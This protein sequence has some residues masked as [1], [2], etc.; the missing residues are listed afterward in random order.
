MNLMSLLARLSLDSSEYQQGLADSEDKA[1][2]AGS[3]IAKALGTM[4][5][6]VAAAS[7][8][9]AAAVG[10]LTYDAINSYGDYEQLLGGVET[11]FKDSADIVSAYAENAYKTAG[12]SSNEYMETVTSFSASLLQSLGGDT[13]KAAEYADL[14]ITDMSDNANKMGSSMESIQFAYQGFAKQ[15]YTMLDNLKL[16]YGGTKTEMERLIKDAEQLDDTFVATRDANG[17]LA[18][19]YSDIVDAIHIVQTEMGITGTTAKEASE[20]IQG[21]VNSM[22]ASWKNL[23]TGLGNTDADLSGLV[24]NF[25]DSLETAFSNIVPVAEQALT[26]MGEALPQLVGNLLPKFTQ[27]INNLLP[28]LIETV[29]NLVTSIGNA[30]P[31]I[32]SGL[33][34]VLPNLLQSIFSN[35]GEIAGN[36]LPSLAESLGSVLVNLPAMLVSTVDGLITGLSNMVTGIVDAVKKQ[37]EDSIPADLADGYVGKIQSNFEKSFSEGMTNLKLSVANLIGNTEWADAL[38]GIQLASQM[39]D[40]IIAD[41]ETAKQN[42]Q[43]YSFENFEI[44]TEAEIN[45]AMTLL[46]ALEGLIT[47]EDGSISA[48]NLGVA[49]TYIDQI[50]AILG[51]GAVELVETPAEW[52]LQIKDRYTNEDGT[53]NVGDPS[54]IKSDIE[55]YLNS[56]FASDE[57]VDLNTQT[58]NAVSQVLSAYTEQDAIADKA[59]IKQAI[60]ELLEQGGVPTVDAEVIANAAVSDGAIYTWY[61]TGRSTS[62]DN[63]AFIEWMQKEGYLPTDANPAKT[64]AVAE[65]ATKFVMGD[66]DEREFADKLKELGLSDEEIEQVIKFTVDHTEVD[67]AIKS[68]KEMEAQQYK[69]QLI[70]ILVDSQINTVK[71]FSE[72]IK[73]ANLAKDAFTSSPTAPEL[74][75]FISHVNT[76]TLALNSEKE[77]SDEVYGSLWDL[78][79]GV[80]GYTDKEA[81]LEAM[82][83]ENQGFQNRKDEL[84]GLQQALQDHAEQLSNTADRYLDLSDASQ[85]TINKILETTTTWDGA[86]ESLGLNAEQAGILKSGLQDLTGW[87]DQVASGV[88]NSTEEA[89][90]WLTGNE[91]ADAL[92]QQLGI[93]Y[94]ALASILVAL[95][96]NE[97]YL[98]DATAE[99]NEEV[100]NMPPNAEKYS[101]SINGMAEDTENATNTMANAAKKTK[102]DVSG[103]FDDLAEEIRNSDVPDNVESLLDG[104]DSSKADEKMKNFSNSFM[105]KLKEGIEGQQANVTGAVDTV[106]AGMETSINPIEDAMSSAGDT[107]ASNLDSSFGAWAVTVERTVTGM[108][109]LFQNI[110]GHALPNDMT[111]W[112]TTIGSNFDSGFASG[113]SSAGSTAE[114]V[115]YSVIDGLDWLYNPMYGA[116]DNAGAGFYSGLSS[117]GW[118]ISSRAWDIANSVVQ[119]TNAALRSRSPSRAM[120]EAG[121]YAGEGLLI[122]LSEW[123]QPVKEEAENI[124]N[125]ILGAFD[126]EYSDELGLED[127][128][129]TIDASVTS[130]GNQQA[131]LYNLLMEYLPQLANMQVVIDGD[132]EVGALMPK[133]DRALAN[134]DIM[135]DRGNAIY[136]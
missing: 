31:D 14:A 106:E 58:Y 41:Y 43:Q 24:N 16:G 51:D 54:I 27:A 36:L 61:N 33:V 48:Q 11:L 15:N 55:S 68:L 77:M 1:R 34:K 5:E 119:A 69:N 89:M 80:E 79:G 97:E 96:E 53:V 9:A 98:G 134:A 133:I 102:N 37:A 118:S 28:N 84:E 81:Y 112:G 73:E 123:E 65:V 29:G 38:E 44:K 12:I 32:T 127:V 93:S 132:K 7:A 59:N 78:M 70:S 83:N 17:D 110:L 63:S 19:S 64:E 49:Q 45:T 50:N 25:T 111:I 23:V 121:G 26:S 120:M 104:V 71:D 4:G 130:A 94:E 75:E 35:I 62:W 128:Q 72:A 47:G 124:A 8:V 109:N 56:I 40:K 100:G 95:A 20:T 82:L 46:G 136:A 76:A 101:E 85:D 86:A 39:Q 10:K 42:V 18:M 108:Y 74:E 117:W 6:A 107:S 113:A 125:G 114:G 103:D 122:G 92:A 88:A 105:T 30:L 90:Y 13:E 131:M 115:A 52:L 21:S 2:S 91:Q 66:I 99:V 3:R 67:D 22:K 126:N 87:Y 135:T 60:Q 57:A 129:S 116:G